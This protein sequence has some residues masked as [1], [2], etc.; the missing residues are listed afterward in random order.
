MIPFPCPWCEHEVLVT[1]EVEVGASL[2]CDDCATVV[3]LAPP[4][5]SEGSQP[6]PLAA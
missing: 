3:D 4:P 1:D 6:M 2:R 5:A